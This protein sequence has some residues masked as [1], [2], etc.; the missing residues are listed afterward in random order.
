[1]SKVLGLLILLVHTVFC[2][3]PSDIAK[4]FL[5]T[6]IVPDVI[7][8]FNPSVTLEVSFGIQITA[9]QSLTTNATAGMPSFTTD[10][11]GTFV[12]LIVSCSV[13]SSLT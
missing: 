12:I 11:N 9:G 7:P 6:Q 5:T 10:G 13:V 8:S 2:Q 3:S 1:M 4:V